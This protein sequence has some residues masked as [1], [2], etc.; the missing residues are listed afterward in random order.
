MFDIIVVSAVFQVLFIKKIEEERGKHGAF[1]P[2]LK[3]GFCMASSYHLSS[4]N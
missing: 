3:P 4:I 2:R 1:C